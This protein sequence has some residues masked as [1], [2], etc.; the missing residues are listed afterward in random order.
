MPG[1]HVRE[2]QV[3][4]PR[5]T[6][7]DRRERTHHV[8]LWQARGHSRFLVEGVPVPLAA[9]T[10]MWLPAGTEHRFTTAPNSALMPMFFES[11]HLSAEM[12]TA[13]VIS[14]DSNAETLCLAL[15]GSQYSLVQPSADLESMVLA[16]VEADL[17]APSDTPMPR[18]L[19]A[20][21]MARSIALN[22]ADR[23]RLADWAAELH[24]SARTLERTFVGETG[25]SWQRWRQGRRMV[26][27]AQLL[28]STP[29]DVT[30]IARRVGFG[31]PSAFSRAFRQHHDMTPTQYREL[32][33]APKH[34]VDG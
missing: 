8:L 32:A 15:I 26:R 31:T 29:L 7:V 13:A 24:V 1:T 21:R 23:R 20:L 10:A 3:E 17:A 6:L 27:A 22:P 19:A 34:A 25:Q 9:G 14:I 28:R 18:S 4:V 30:D 2:S 33:R 12:R 5:F 11:R 16:V